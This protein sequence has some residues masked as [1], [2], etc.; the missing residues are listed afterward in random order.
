MV[1]NA[2]AKKSASY[3]SRP[4]QAFLQGMHLMPLMVLSMSLYI[5]TH[6]RS[7]VATHIHDRIQT[8][9]RTHA[10]ADIQNRIR[11]Y[12]PKDIEIRPTAKD[13]TEFWGKLHIRE[14]LHSWLVID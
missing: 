2:P 3:T 10:K 9:I 14:K 5:E 12:I 11:A 6:I 8:D 4:H 1:D 7:H 13:I